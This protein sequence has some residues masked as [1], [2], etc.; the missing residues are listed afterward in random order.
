M[1]TVVVEDNENLHQQWRKE[2]KKETNKQ[3][4]VSER[5]L[6]NDKELEDEKEEEAERARSKEERQRKYENKVTRYE[7]G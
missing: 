4:W 6:H 7:L 5:N 1:K 2:T 3:W